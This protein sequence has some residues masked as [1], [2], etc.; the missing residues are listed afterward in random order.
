[1]HS[2]KIFS[3]EMEM[4]IKAVALHFTTTSIYVC[5]FSIQAGCIINKIYLVFRILSEQ[6]HA[7]TTKIK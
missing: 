1:M 2:L 3:M 7:T 4:K 5:D 6:V